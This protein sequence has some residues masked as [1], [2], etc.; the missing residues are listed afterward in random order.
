VPDRHYPHTLAEGDRLLYV[1]PVTVE[2]VRPDDRVGVALPSGLSLTVRTMSLRPLRPELP[3]PTVRFE[4]A[5]PA[6]P[7]LTLP[8]VRTRRRLTIMPTTLRVI[9]GGGL[10]VSI[11]GPTVKPNGH[12]GQHVRTHA[13]HELADGTG[14]HS[15]DVLPEWA[16]PYLQFVRATYLGKDSDHHG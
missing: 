12:A 4:W 15:F 3:E 9:A 16:S 11:D 14:R 13:F 5:L 7:N 8:D 1:M 6:V 2:D 10:T